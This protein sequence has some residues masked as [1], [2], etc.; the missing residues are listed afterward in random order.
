MYVSTGAS[1]SDETPMLDASNEAVSEAILEALADDTAL[2]GTLRTLA[3][4]FGVPSTAFRATLRTLLETE[5][6]VVRAG[7]KGQ[8]TIRRGP[9]VSTPLPALAPRGPRSS[10]R[11]DAPRVWIM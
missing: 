10:R 3:H 9:Y 1:K 2:I 5:K 8:L 7:P 4:S 11:G 6:I